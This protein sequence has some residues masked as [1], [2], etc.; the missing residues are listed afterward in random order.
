MGS[1][2]AIGKP[3]LVN[4]NRNL[5]ATYYRDEI[6]YAHV[7]SFIR[8]Q[9]GHIHLQQNAGECLCVAIACCLFWSCTHV[10]NV[11]VRT[12]FAK[13]ASEVV[14]F[15]SGVI[16]YMERLFASIFSCLVDSKRCL[17][18]ICVNA[19]ADIHVLILWSDFWHPCYSIPSPNDITN[20]VTFEHNR[21]YFLVHN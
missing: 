8:G 5:K 12:C 17:C 2:T 1:K 13:S 11:T 19:S 6:L 21:I 20:A 3:Y 16:A 14:N 4:I 7:I 15:D 10:V 18:H 9:H